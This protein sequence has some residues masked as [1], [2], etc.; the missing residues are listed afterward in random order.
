[1]QF[2]FEAHS[3]CK[4]VQFVRGSVVKFLV[5]QKSITKRKSIKTGTNYALA[6]K[7]VKNNYYKQ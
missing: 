6:N 1:M 2:A 5:K 4:H 3:N 7:F